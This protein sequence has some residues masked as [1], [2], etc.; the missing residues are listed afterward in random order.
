[1]PD[2]RRFRAGNQLIWVIV[3]VFTQ[4][5]G[6]IIYVAVGRPEKRPPV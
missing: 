2:D 5:I 6:S 1:V 4:V 3:I